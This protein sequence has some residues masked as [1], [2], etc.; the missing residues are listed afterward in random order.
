MQKIHS[1]KEYPALTASP[2]IE[3]LAG[4]T[5]AALDLT[6]WDANL[7]FYGELERQLGAYGASRRGRLYL[8]ETCTGVGG[9]ALATGAEILIDAVRGVACSALLEAWV[10]AQPGPFS[11]IAAQEALTDEVLALPGAVLKG[12]NI[13]LFTHTRATDVVPLGEELIPGCAHPLWRDWSSLDDLLRAGYRVFGISDDHEGIISHAGIWPLS[14]L[15]A[16]IVMVA[17]DPRYVGKGYATAVSARALDVA[18][19]T[20]RVV[21]W[22]TDL[23]NVAS[24]RVAKKLGFRELLTLYH[25]DVP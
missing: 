22:S 15:R 25:V 12:R 7:W 24:I 10:T 13:K 5:Y 3:F 19:E 11:I 18:L 4:H 17:T 20:A 6:L 14:A 2:A 16:E 1:W 9:V 23:D 21:T 8:C